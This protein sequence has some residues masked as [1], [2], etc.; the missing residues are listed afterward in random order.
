MPPLDRAIPLPQPNTP[1]LLVRKHL[2]LDMP[3]PNEVSLQQQLVVPEALDG[4][5]LG[6]QDL[7]LKVGH[8]VYYPH[9]FAA[10]AMCGLDEN[11]EADFVSGSEERWRVLG[12][13]VI[14]TANVRFSLSSGWGPG[15][16]DTGDTSSYKLS[17]PFSSRPDRD[18]G[19]GL[20]EHNLLAFSLTPHTPYSFWRRSNERK[21][22]LLHPLRKHH[23][24]GQ[25]AVAWMYR[26]WNQPVLLL[27][28]RRPSS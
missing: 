11:G 4:L 16:R 27:Y 2:H 25:K 26:L 6:R 12:G 13:A 21:A 14:S 24:L 18:A 9:A 23:R 28:C 10:A 15:L 7:L 22:S 3:R 17:A 1:A 8:I 5:P 19:E 20:T